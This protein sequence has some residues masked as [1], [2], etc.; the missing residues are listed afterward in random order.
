L[1]PDRDQGLRMT[2]NDP[3]LELIAAGN[4]LQGQKQLFALPVLPAATSDDTLIALNRALLSPPSEE[5]AAVVQLAKE[6]HLTRLGSA[7]GPEVPVLM[8]NLGCFALYQDDIQEAQVRFQEVLKLDPGNRYARHNLAY[9]YELMAELAEARSQYEKVAEGPEGVPLSRLNQALV[10]AED[11]DS[12]GAV[13]ELRALYLGSPQ[14][15]GLLL[16]LCRALLAGANKEGAKEV[17][18]L[19]D[20][21]KE[22]L[23]FLDL[24]ECRAYALYQLGEN[25][26]AESAFRELLTASP[27]SLF[28]R[29]GLIKTLA[30]RGNFA[31]LKQELERYASL[32]PPEDLSAVLALARAI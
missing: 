15:M 4:T 16:Y 12:Q 5:N 24:W 22:W 30:V 28:S 6:D 3:I 21:R 31:E 2:K 18:S 19:L 27:E 29:L 9:T 26:E 8:Y 10:R 14:N 17:V 11:G 25:N 7:A 13:D 23:E 32:N 1:L 20:Q